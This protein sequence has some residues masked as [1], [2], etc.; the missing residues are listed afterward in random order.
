MIGPVDETTNNADYDIEVTAVDVETGDLIDFTGA[1]IVVAMKD[2]EG[3]RK[4]EARTDN[5]SI[6]ILDVGVI[7]ISFPVEQMRCVL[8][9][10]YNI[11]GVYKLNDKTVPLLLGTVTVVDG[12]AFI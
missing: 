7:G 10:S 11:G 12:V 1:I 9:G 5:G 6:V 4:L 8:P 3:C 2:G